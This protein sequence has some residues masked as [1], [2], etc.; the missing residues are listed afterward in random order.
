[1]YSKILSKFVSLGCFKN[2]IVLKIASIF[3]FD[4]SF[5]NNVLT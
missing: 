2:C 1:M 5:I 4:D 3:T